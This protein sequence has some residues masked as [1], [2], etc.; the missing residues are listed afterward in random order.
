VEVA[1]PAP[2]R[3]GALEPLTERLRQLEALAAA[4]RAVGDDERAH[5]ALA[6]AA[7]IEP[8]SESLRVALAATERRL[9]GQ[10]Q[11]WRQEVEE[12]LA[13]ARRSVE[14]KR[15]RDAIQYAELAIA[16]DP[17]NL[18]A[19]EIVAESE[20]LAERESRERAPEPAAKRVAVQDV[21]PVPS[22]TEPKGEPAPAEPRKPAPVPM[23]S[24]SAPGTLVIELSAAR[25]PGVLT[26]YEGDEQIFRERF[27][28]TKEKKTFIG[29]LTARPIGG[30]LTRQ[31]SHPPD[32]LDLR[33]YVSIPDSPTQVF[34]LAV[35]LDP[36]GRRVL[37]VHVDQAGVA[38][39][40][41]E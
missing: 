12:S 24:P 6:E 8:G 16:L 31:V 19:P 34:P 13:A 33:L 11:S 40:G 9:H 10:R 4:Y 5:L 35:R 25:S 41:V 27:R 37:W 20:R 32:E 30:S 29:S 14:E 1:V 39:V 15:Y 3:V 21:P 7:R 22:T 38:E 28:F 18:E 23:V 17:L 36:A 26:L 2:P